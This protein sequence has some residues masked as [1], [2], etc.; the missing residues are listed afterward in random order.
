MCEGLSMSP[1][2]PEDGITSLELELQIGVHLQ[3]GNVNYRR[4]EADTPKSLQFKSFSD[5]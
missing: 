5:S 3:I 1:W 2:R 4:E